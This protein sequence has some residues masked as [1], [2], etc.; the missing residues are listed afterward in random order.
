MAKKTYIAPEIVTMELE[1]VQ[2]LAGSSESVR[3]GIDHTPKVVEGCSRKYKP[4][5]T[6]LWDK[7]W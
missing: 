1:S 7:E 6:N 4:K 3:V 2:M 5:P